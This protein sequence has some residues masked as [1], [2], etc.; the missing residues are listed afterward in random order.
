MNINDD[1]TDDTPQR[2]HGF[3]RRKKIVIGAIG[4]AIIALLVAVSLVWWAS[5]QNGVENEG[6]SQQRDIQTLQ[7]QVGIT[8]STCLDN[9]KIASQIAITQTAEVRKTIVDAVSAR[10][11]DKHGVSNAAV[12][13]AG[14]RNSFLVMQERYPQVDIKVWDHLMTVS[15]GCR[16]QV[17]G[18]QNHLQQY[19]GVFDK[20]RLTGGL[21]DRGIRRKFPSNDLVFINPLTG[22]VS[23]GQV[24]L[25]FLTRQIITG[26]AKKA[27]G[28]GEM[29]E[30]SLFPS[31]TKK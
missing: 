7:A 10:F 8:L 29:P 5:F 12:T 19:A 30:Q 18:V 2:P 26:E 17:A 9:S 16:D 20:W 15:T 25:G 3:N 14:I 24:A 23:R 22:E 6:K 21:L 27:I 11:E 31:P 28:N 13:K 4:A 1:M